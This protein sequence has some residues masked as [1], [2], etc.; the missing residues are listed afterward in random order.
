[1]TSEFVGSRWWKFDFHTHTPASEDY[2]KGPDQKR[3]RARSPREW[4]LDFMRAEIDCVAVTDHNSGA[5]IDELK[6]AY[7]DLEAQAPPEFRPLHIFPGVEVHVNGGVHVLAILGPEK[8]SSDI[9]SLLGAV[10]LPGSA[11]ASLDGCSSQS[12]VQVA[13]AIRRAGGLAIPAHVDGH[14]GL[15]TVCGVEP[16]AR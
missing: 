2:G 12:V 6:K 5:W 7:A 1:M 8:R 10:G 16:P 4:L 14:S 9:D 13:G 3:L 15:F 11:S